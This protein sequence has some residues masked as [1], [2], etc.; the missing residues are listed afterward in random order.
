MRRITAM[1]AVGDF[2]FGP[3]QLDT[4]LKRLLR[5]GVPVS[6]SLRLYDLL[7]AF[8]THPGY[9]FSKDELIRIGWHD[10][11]VSDSSVEKII[12]QLRERLDPSHER[13]IAT[14]PR[15]GYKFVAEV[16]PGNRRDGDVD[17]DALLAPHRSWVEGRAALETL[18]YE[19][20]VS[21]RDVFTNLVQ[22]YPAHAPFHVAM[23]NACVMQFEATRTDAAPDVA[24][25]RLAV[26]HS[27][28]AC[29]LDPNLAEAWATRGFVL[30][31]AGK[32]EDALGALAKA[33][34]LEGGN[35]RHQF[36]LAMG[37][38]GEPRLEAVR[39]ALAKC[40]HLPMAHF[41]A[42]MV[43]VARHALAEAEREIDGGLATVE[44]ELREESKLL[45]VALYW[46]KGLLC[47]AR[48]AYD[49]A[50]AAFERE[51]ALEA[52][53]HF[54]ARECAANT[55][56]AK[57]ACFL[58]RNRLDD[59]RAAF[60]QAL[61]RVPLHPG[62]R[63]GLRIVERR[64]SGTSSS[65]DPFEGPPEGAP[66]RFET[67][68]AHAAWLV[69]VGDQAGAVKVLGNALAGAPRGTSGWTIPIDPMLQVVEHPDAY[70]SLLGTLHV[71]AR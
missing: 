13:Y 63:M 20:I 54:Y 56:Y 22:M 42:A 29:L 62:A 58:R 21:S 10:V 11:V 45:S 18:E 33:V 65:H 9:V 59:A 6:L 51:L 36:R 16:V 38:W 57:G 71:R 12:C 2:G 55:W 68:M 23:A 41:L 53:G 39:Q 67:Y 44:A 14:V 50:M 46:L 70:T 7:H 64:S 19:Q 34:F 4:R 25:L 43:H 3:Y 48:G 37:T 60:E 66:L 32:P 52:R 1:L 61:L 8:V 35:W 31:R 28:K 30:L 24:S 40:P 26:G 47:L 49:D 17:L 5:D 27:E 69:E 15:H